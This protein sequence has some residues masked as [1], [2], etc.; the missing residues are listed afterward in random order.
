MN[1]DMT[2]LNRLKIGI[3]GCGRLGQA[4]AR[5][6]E[7]N[8]LLISYRGTPLT[9][10]KLEEQELAECLCTNEQVFQDAGL[11]LLTTRPQD[12]PML[13]NVKVSEKTCLVS[14]AT[15][16]P[17]ELLSKTFGTRPFG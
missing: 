12:I 15:G 9:Y 17:V 14:C 16:V 7:K 3:V 13:R 2:Q 4:V 6:F 5:G 10:Q 11:V 8:R 1:G